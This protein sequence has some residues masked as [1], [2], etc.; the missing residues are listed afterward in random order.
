MNRIHARVRGHAPSGAPYRAMDP[1][2]LLWVQ[3]T[4]VLTSLRVYEAVLRRLPDRDR[5]AYWSETKPIAEA[6]GIPADRLPPTLADLERYEAAMLAGE[7]VPD[8]TAR[9]VGRDVLRPIT[10]VP[11]AIYWPSDAIAAAL[12]PPSLRAPFGLRYGA[13]ERIFFRAVVVAVRWIRRVMPDMLTVVPQARR[14]ER[15]SGPQG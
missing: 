7:V 3:A 11:D 1:A 9:R 13:A 4:L 10:W 6:L 14:Y 5:E 8:A 12:L 15:A 2:L